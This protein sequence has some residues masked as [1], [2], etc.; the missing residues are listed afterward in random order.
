[1][2][3]AVLG[4]GSAGARHARHL[5]ELGHSVSA[6]DPDAP[7]VPPGLSLARSPEQAVDSADAAIVASPNSAHAEQALMALDAGCH[8]LVEKPI[9]TEVREA[10][11]LVEIARERGLVAGVAMNLRF[12]PPLQALKGL[13]GGGELGRI[14]LAQASF[15]FDLR[16]WRPGTDYRRSYSARSELG[17]GIV[18]D[19]I[20]ELDYLLWLLGP[21]T[22]VAAHVARASELEADVEAVAVAALEF[23]SGALGNLDLNFVEPSYRRGCLLAGDRATARWEWEDQTVVIR[24]GESERVLDARG[25]VAETYR[26]ELAD[27]ADAVAQG[28]PPATPLEEGLRA[29]EL[30]VS[31]KE[32]AA[33][34]RYCRPPLS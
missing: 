24:S 29:L 31:I 13:V 12:H 18:L 19:A 25:D 32:S 22:S 4:L 30:A 7:D 14:F 9:A 23:A 26:A 17:G 15:G 21:V 5:L 8:V 6:W 33:E 20:H 1:M 34:R 28:R 2:R 3:F 11:R 27:F 16:R 10:R